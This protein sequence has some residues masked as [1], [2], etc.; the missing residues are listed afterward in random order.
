[1]LQAVVLSAEGLETF[2]NRPCLVQKYHD[3]GGILCKVYVIAEDIF[4]CTRRSLPNL[5]A[6][7]DSLAA[8]DSGVRTA[9]VFDSRKAYPQLRDFYTTGIASD[10]NNNNNNNNNN[11][12][13]KEACDDEELADS[14]QTMNSYRDVFRSYARQLREGL[15][16]TLF[17]FDVIVPVSGSDKGRAMVID[18]NFFPSYK[19]VVDFPDRL[20]DFL[21]KAH[22]G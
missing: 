17:G 12:E 9:L 15:G 16:L 8:G 21:K 11:K 5:Q 1:M 22:N 10:N 19:E 3:H 13:E 2:K 18:V 14:H 7:T 20:C 4:V 6:Q